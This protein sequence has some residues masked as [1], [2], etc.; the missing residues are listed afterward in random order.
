MFLA[1]HALCADGKPRSPIAWV[2]KARMNEGAAHVAD[3]EIP[4]RLE[5]PCASCTPKTGSAPVRSLLQHRDKPISRAEPP[6][7]AHSPPRS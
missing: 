7:W 2:S 1:L 6:Y 3:A 4:R 5:S